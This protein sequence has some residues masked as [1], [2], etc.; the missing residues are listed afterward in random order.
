L[1][2]AAENK[3]AEAWNVEVLVQQFTKSCLSLLRR[4]IPCDNLELAGEI[5]D[6]SGWVRSGLS[7]DRDREVT[8]VARRERRNMAVNPSG[9]NLFGRARPDAL[10]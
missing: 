6:E 1:R 4:G 9:V 10:G 5:V 7:G 2:G 8:E 3:A